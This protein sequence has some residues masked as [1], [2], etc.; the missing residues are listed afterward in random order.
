MDER[1]TSLSNGVLGLALGVTSGGLTPQAGPARG[2]S[3]D[4]TGFGGGSGG[5]VGLQGGSPSSARGGSLDFA[6]FGGFGEQQGGGPG[7]SRDARLLLDGLQGG[8]GGSALAAAE[9][10]AGWPGQEQ[11]QRHP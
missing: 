2:G 8:G 11:P 7:G 3:M 9:E 10:G 1:F 6:G 4:L 5:G